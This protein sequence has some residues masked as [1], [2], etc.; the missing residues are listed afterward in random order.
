MNTAEVHKE[1]S[2]LTQGNQAVIISRVHTPAEKRAGQADSHATQGFH[3]NSREQEV[4]IHTTVSHCGFP[5]AATSTSSIDSC[6]DPASHVIKHNDNANISCLEK[7]SSKGTI[8]VPPVLMAIQSMKIVISRLFIDALRGTWCQRGLTQ[9]TH[10]NKAWSKKDHALPSGNGLDVKANPGKRFNL[11]THNMYTTKFYECNYKRWTPE[12]QNGNNQWTPRNPR[13]RIYHELIWSFGRTQKPTKVRLWA[14]H[15]CH[16]PTPMAHFF[17]N[18]SHPNRSHEWSTGGWDRMSLVAGNSHAWGWR[19]SMADNSLSFFNSTSSAVCRRTWHELQ[20][21]SQPMNPHATH[22][23]AFPH[24]DFTSPSGQWVSFWGSVLDCWYYSARIKRMTWYI[25]S[26]YSHASHPT[27]TVC[28]YSHQPDSNNVFWWLYNPTVNPQIQS[29]M[30]C[31][32]QSV[33]ICAKVPSR[34]LILSRNY[35]IFIQLTS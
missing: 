16:P 22:V 24:Q 2:D 20:Q 29:G 8:S 35:L 19:G 9:R 12:R 25:N 32:F 5:R 6:Y 27:L 11:S 3:G 4:D 33:W 13:H 1:V 31:N 14:V 7:S 34:K 30:G 28:Q 10:D 21:S 26:K 15:W 17:F 18:F 23:R